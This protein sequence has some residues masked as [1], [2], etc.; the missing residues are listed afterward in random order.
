MMDRKDVQMKCP[1]TQTEV[2]ADDCEM[3]VN[4]RICYE[5]CFDHLVFGRIG[6]PLFTHEM[7]KYG[8]GLG[9]LLSPPEPE[10]PYKK[11]TIP[12]WLRWDIWQRDNFTCQ[13]CGSRKYLTIDHIVPESKGGE[14]ETSNLQTLCKRCNSRKGNRL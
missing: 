10:E 4:E 12:L 13:I 5:W 14:T 7:G 8:E 6:E 2:T 9:Q 3:C 11:E 1:K